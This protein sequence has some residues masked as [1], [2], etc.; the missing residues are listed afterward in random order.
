MTVMLSTKVNRCAPPAVFGGGDAA[1][2][3]E[4]NAA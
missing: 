2:A 3:R 4:E 1:C